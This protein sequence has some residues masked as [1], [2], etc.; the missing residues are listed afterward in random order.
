MGIF[1]SLQRDMLAQL[2]V[3]IR[4]GRGP[5][6]EGTAGLPAG[7]EG[8]AIVIDDNCTVRAEASLYLRLRLTSYQDYVK[9]RPIQAPTGRSGIPESV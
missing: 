5:G 9:T 1:L 2:A 4:A 7:E 6:G 8:E 3:R